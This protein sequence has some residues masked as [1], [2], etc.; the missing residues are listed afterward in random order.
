[1]DCTS[2]VLAEEKQPC[3]LAVVFSFGAGVR[4]QKHNQTSEKVKTNAEPCRSVARI[5]G[6]F[7]SQFQTNMAGPN[8]RSCCWYVCGEVT[9]I[10]LSL[11]L[12][13]RFA[14]PMCWST[15]TLFV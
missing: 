11:V 9:G 13:T 4:R 6:A 1:M 2:A 12:M 15:D 3:L 5:P 8:S 7:E 10:E 14:S